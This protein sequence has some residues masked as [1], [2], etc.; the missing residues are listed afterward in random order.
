MRRTL[1]RLVPAMFHR[2]LWLLVILALTT[3][4]VLAVQTAHLTV[5]QGRHLRQAAEAILHHQRAT[6]TTRGTIRDRYGRILAQDHSSYNLAVDYDFLTGVWAEKC[7]RR[8]AINKHKSQWRQLDNVGKHQLVEQYLPPYEQQISQLWQTLARLT[9]TDVRELDRRRTR[10]IHRVEAIA[11]SRQRWLLAQRAEKFAQITGLGDVMRQRVAEQESRHVFIENITD[12]ARFEIE[13]Y[14]AT[15]PQAASPSAWA[16]VRVVFDNRRQYGRQTYRVSL[17]RATLPAP[18]RRDDTI[19]LDV[20]NVG[21][22][23]TGGMRQGIWASDHAPPYRQRRPDGTTQINPRGYLPSDSIGVRGIEKTLESHLRGARGSIT[24][25]R[26][27][28][29]DRVERPTP[30]RDVDLT[31]DI[32]LQARLAAIMATGDSDDSHPPGL[33]LMRAQPWHRKPKGK[34][35]I[36][37]DGEPLAGAAVV[38]EVHSG[39]VLAAVSTPT[40][41]PKQLDGDRDAIKLW[42]AINKPYLNRTVAMPYPPGSTIKPLILAALYSEGKLQPQDTLSCTPGY[43]YPNQPH[44]YRCWLYKTYGRNHGPLTGPDMIKVSCNVCFFRAGQRLGAPGLRRWFDKF[45]LG[46]L[47]RSGL[48]DEI[49]TRG[50]TGRGRSAAALMAIGQGPVEWTVL[51]AASAYA[52]LA[53]GGVAIAPTFIKGSIHWPSGRVL[54]LQL[55][56]VAVDLALEGLRRSANH[57]DGTAS[58]I[59]TPAGREHTFNISGVELLAKSGTAEAPDLRIKIKNEQGKKVSRVVRQGDHGWVIVLVK[60]PGSLRP[61]FVIAVIVE[62][63][64]SGG[65]V[66]GPIVNQILYALRSEAYL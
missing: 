34:P 5:I 24:T 25:F 41:R 39:H 2:R 3:T 22:Q 53:R 46:R 51:Q 64:G 8:D 55:D 30:G 11:L 48:G 29:P 33:G 18:L 26:D 16:Q 52:T 13:R 17:E 42:Q 61:D 45:G 59:R 37:R 9:G 23:I 4:A 36:P 7:A 44:R 66:A 38:L 58:R 43:L 49:A 14:I 21:R 10:I 40:H 28:R 54:D 63:G 15:A 19:E 12:T 32:Q 27:G 60:R 31:I 50:G 65:H 20:Q 35:L 6:P 1:R 47:P 56:P 62:Y 57:R